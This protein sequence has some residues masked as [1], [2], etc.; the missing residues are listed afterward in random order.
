MA[1]THPELF[2]MEEMAGDVETEGELTT[3]ATVFDRRRV[4]AWR[5]NMEVAID[6]QNADKRDRSQIVAGLN[7]AAAT[8]RMTAGRVR[9]TGSEPIGNRRRLE[10]A[11]IATTVIWITIVFRSRRTTS[12]HVSC[13]PRSD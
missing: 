13:P 6:M 9:R 5:H 3:G 12:G 8:G 11:A 7:D 10:L 1:V 4:P 2:V